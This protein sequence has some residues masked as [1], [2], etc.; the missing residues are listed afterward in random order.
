MHGDFRVGNILYD[1][2]GLTA[3]LDW[4][5]VHIGEP[6]EDLAWFCTRVWRFGMIEMEAGGIASRED[7]L[8]AY[9]SAS[10]LAISLLV[11][12]YSMDIVHLGAPMAR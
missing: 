5:G 12:R 10:G 9:E 8:C 2:E 6:E 4:E 7:W 3:V 1:E 11:K